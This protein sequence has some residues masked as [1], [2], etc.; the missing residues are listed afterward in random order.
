MPQPKTT[1]EMGDGRARSA[2]G[3][4]RSPGHRFRPIWQA[5]GYKLR[6]FESARPRDPWRW[7]HHLGARLAGSV[8]LALAVAVGLA[9]LALWCLP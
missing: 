9:Y 2:R 1:S 8:A 6:K 5:G 3:I 4:L 7:R